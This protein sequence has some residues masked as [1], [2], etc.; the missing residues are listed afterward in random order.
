MVNNIEELQQPFTY[1]AEVM[2]SILSRELVPNGSNIIVTEENKI[3]FITRLCE[4]KTRDEISAEV[5]AFLRGFD[6]IIPLTFLSVFSPSELQL[7]IAGVPK[8]D[9]Q[10]M[11][12]MQFTL[13]LVMR[14]IKSNG[15]GRF[16]ESF[17][18]KNL[19]PSCFSS[20]VSFI[21]IK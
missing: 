3:T 2:G 15:Y 5:S 12:N 13:A 9:V 7:L 10:E 1:E 6:F 19:V 17:L 16:S 8:I 11:K 21:L 18:R 20:Q 4:M 14:M